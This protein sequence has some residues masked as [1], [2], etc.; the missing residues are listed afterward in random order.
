MAILKT[1]VYFEVKD[2]GFYIPSFLTLEEAEQHVAQ[3]AT[4]DY[5]SEENKQYW[6]NRKPNLR[7]VKV[8]TTEE[9]V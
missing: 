7:I 6:T 3:Y 8:T 1:Y 9:S 4:K 2:E 5:D